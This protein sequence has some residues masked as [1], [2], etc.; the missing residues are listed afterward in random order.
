MRILK[1]LGLG[2]SLFF[3]IYSGWAIIGG[4][5]SKP[6]PHATALS[7]VKAGMTEA[8]HTPSFWLS[9]LL[10]AAVSYGLA[11]WLVRK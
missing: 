8:L 5:L 4:L 7:A 6:R 2:T 11:F 3:L 9:I 10:T 1:I